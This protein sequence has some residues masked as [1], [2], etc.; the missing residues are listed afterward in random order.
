MCCFHF[1]CSEMKKKTL[2]RFPSMY[3]NK[4]QEE[5][6]QDVVNMN[7]VKS[8]PF[9]DLVDQDFSQFDEINY[10]DPHCHIEND[11]TSGVEYL[12]DS[13]DTETKLLQFPAYVTNISR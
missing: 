13:E 6:V 7:I 9:G 1:I 10:Q 3:Q 8:E 11:G 5:G 12:N 4:L 2:T